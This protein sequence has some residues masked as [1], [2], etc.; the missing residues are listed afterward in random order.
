[1]KLDCDADDESKR[2]MGRWDEAGV[3]YTFFFSSRSLE[4][5]KQK[6]F[7]LKKE[8]Y[9]GREYVKDRL[10]VSNVFPFVTETRSSPPQAETTTRLIRPTDPDGKTP[11]PPSRRPCHTH[12]LVHHPGPVICAAPSDPGGAQKNFNSG[13]FGSLGRKIFRW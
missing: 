8:L 5:Q 7:S 13:S 4:I 11:L 12:P 2:P 3:I 9:P 1:M 10:Q 6:N